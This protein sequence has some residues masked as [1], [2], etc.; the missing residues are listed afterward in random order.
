MHSDSTTPE[1]GPRG[2]HAILTALAC[3]HPR[4]P[5]HTAAHRGHGDTHCPAHCDEHPSLSVTERDGNILVHWNAGCSQGTVLD[6][7]RQR[8]LWPAQFTGLTMEQLAG[9]KQLPV[10]HLE[11]LGVRT[12]FLRDQPRVRIP[13]SDDIGEVKAIRYRLSLVGPERFIWRRGD[14]PIL[15]GLPKLLDAYKQG[16]VILCEGESDCWTAWQ[17]GLPAL[18]VPGKSTWRSEWAKFFTEQ[19]ITIYL[20]REPD[21]DSLVECVARDLPG[22]R[23]IVPPEGLKD[24]SEAHL[25]GEDVFALVQRLRQEARP[26]AELLAMRAQQERTRDAEEAL[27]ASAGLLDDPCFLD[28]VGEILSTRGLAGDKANAQ[29]VYLGLTSRLLDRPVNLLVDGPSSAGKTYLVDSVVALF[30]EEAVYRLTASSERTFVYTTEPFAHRVLLVGEAAGLHKDG[31][32]AAILRELIW[33]GRV[34]YETVEKTPQDTLTTRR[35]EKEGPTGLITTSVRALDGELVTRF[36]TITVPDDPAFTQVVVREL[37]RRAAEVI[38]EVDVTPLVAAQ[39]W[40]ELAG[41]RR[42]RIPYAAVLAQMVDVQA[43]RVRRDFRQLLTL[44]EASAILHQRKRSRDIEGRIIATIEDYR[45]VHRLMARA[46]NAVATDTLSEA[47]RQAVEAVHNLYEEIKTPAT[48]QRVAERLGIDRSAGQR[49]L[50]RPLA[51]GYVINEETRPF[52]PALL[53]PGDPL[54]KDRPAIPIPEE[55]ARSWDGDISHESATRLHPSPENPDLNIPGGVQLGA[56]RADAK[57]TPETLKITEFSGP[58]CKSVV[59]VQ[60]DTIPHSPGPNGTVDDD[61]EETWKP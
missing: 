26:A 60:R 61:Q 37:G 2:T 21:A 52:R 23:V 53:K 39:R 56:L 34:A 55:L 57:C 47:Q 13:Y 35:I 6:A 40:L 29:I 54:P 15:Y 28:R 30:P 1:T 46:F 9:A 27:R 4:C 49:R 44:I 58:A 48:Y 11:S 8:R 17:Y 3:D 36:L 25:R 59:E 22:L 33:T 32:G 10:A 42:V 41:E 24:L 16:W 12:E 50:D 45:I 20:W 14:H 19:E 38:P 31:I 51:K 7:L 18:G 43:V 5:C